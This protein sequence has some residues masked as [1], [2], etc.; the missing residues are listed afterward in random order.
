M[1]QV[2]AEILGSER[3]EGVAVLHLGR[4][5]SFTVICLVHVDGARLVSFRRAAFAGRSVVLFVP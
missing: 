4:F 1:W 3:C 5:H 2:I